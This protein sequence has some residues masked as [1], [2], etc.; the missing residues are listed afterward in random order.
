MAGGESN[1]SGSVTLL[2]SYEPYGSSLSSAGSG[3][4]RYD[5]TG[6]Y[7]DPG[8]L[9]YLQARYY[10]TQGRFLQKDSVTGDPANPQS[11]NRWAYSEGNPINLTD[12]TGHNACLFEFTGKCG[13]PLTLGKRLD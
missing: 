11:L 7:R 1:A 3:F 5:F 13:V 6:E 8:G 10:S 12:P 4:S 2:K 9:I